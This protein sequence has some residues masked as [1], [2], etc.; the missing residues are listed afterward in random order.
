MT[1]KAQSLNQILETDLSQ[2]ALF[3]DWRR[4]AS[5]T[6]LSGSELQKD[7]YHRTNV[8]ISSELELAISKLQIPSERTN[9]LRV[10]PIRLRRTIGT[11]A[12][13]CGYS[14]LV[15]A[16]L[17]DHSDTQNTITYV[18]NAPEQVGLLDEAMTHG[19]AAAAS[20]FIG[21]V[22]SSRDDLSAEAVPVST[23]TGAEV[24]A[25][26]H[27]GP[28]GQL[29][30]FA[31]YTCRSFRAWEE[32]PHE[33]VRDDLRRR[34]RLAADHTSPEVAAVNNRTLTA[35]QEVIEV[36]FAIKASSNA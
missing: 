5:V 20:A 9:E 36:C 33:A 21:Q 24:G 26:E 22:A 16:E 14:S 31:C 19:L 1:T 3:P 35:I 2:L 4:L 7:I 13:R 8:S 27:S 34:E 6:R 10:I 29:V 12:A 23:A 28:C 30:P 15:I 32:G 11:R 18:E 17:L 25:C